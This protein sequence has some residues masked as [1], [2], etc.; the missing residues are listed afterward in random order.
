MFDSFAYI[1]DWSSKWDEQGGSETDGTYTAN[2]HDMGNEFNMRIYTD[3]VFTSGVSDTTNYMDN[4]PTKL[5]SR[6][7]W[8]DPPRLAGVTT[9]LR[10]TLQDPASESATWTEFK[11]FQVADIRARGFQIKT[12]FLSDAEGSEQ[13]RVSALSVLIDM[14]AKLVGE[15][16]KTSNAI[17]YGDAF[18]NRPT[19]VVTPKDLATGDYMQL[20]SE[21]KTGFGINFFNASG[22][23][24]T[25]NYNYL[26]N[27]VG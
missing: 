11:R 21:T 24:V 13:F 20:S 14:K 1:D 25:R 23:A 27:G 9:F 19:L 18:F 2:V 3:K 12:R 6:N 26:A 17:T 15:N 5:D 8:D 22:G 16:D 7:W 4:W 10:T